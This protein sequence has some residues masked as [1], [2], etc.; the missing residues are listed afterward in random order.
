MKTLLAISIILAFS[1]ALSAVGAEASL[2][3][4]FPAESERAWVRESATSPAALA[5]PA[6]GASA[7]LWF[8]PAAGFG[9]IWRE[10]DVGTAPCELSC[11]VELT[12]GQAESWRWPGLVVALAT[13]E[14]AAMGDED[15]ALVLSLHKQG[16]R[17]TAVR[18][19][20]FQPKLKWANGPWHFDEREIPKRFDVSQGGAGGHNYSV[21]WPEKSL[22]G[23]R[24]RLWAARTADGTLRF[25]ASHL[26]G[27]GATWWEAE[28][29]LPQDLASRPLCVLAVRT[30][31][32]PAAPE[33]WIEPLDVAKDIGATM[34][35]GVLRW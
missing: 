17:L 16:L 7:G 27:P 30:V 31:R 32:E 22:A 8:D 28:C 4:T 15:W 13:A 14:P 12:R 18:R 2:D 6:A 26:C 34:P 29:V 35:A 1:L 11:E 5:F 24:L 3:E 19:G 9:S 10:V 21:K 20:I 23:Q 33:P 25:A